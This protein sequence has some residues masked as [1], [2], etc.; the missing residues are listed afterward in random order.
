MSINYTSR[1]LSYIYVL[2]LETEHIIITY[3]FETIIIN[4][5][6]TQNAKH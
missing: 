3:K 5:K 1:I 6:L 4:N 2:L